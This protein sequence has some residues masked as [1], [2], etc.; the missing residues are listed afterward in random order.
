MMARIEA[1]PPYTRNLALNCLTWMIYAQKPL[2]TLD[3]Q[4]ALAMEYKITGRQ[5]L[6]LHPPMVILEACGNLL[7]EIKLQGNYGIIRPIH[8]TVKEFLTSVVE[9][10]SQQTV[11]M[12]LLDS[13]TAHRRLALVC[14]A[15]LNSMAMEEPIR[16]YSELESDIQAN[17]FE[18]YACR[19]FD[20]HVSMCDYPS[21]DIMDELG[22]LFNRKHNY[23]AAIL[24][25]RAYSFGYTRICDTRFPVSPSLVISSTQLYNV[26]SVR[27]RWMVQE[28]PK[29][30]LQLATVAGIK[31]AVSQLLKAGY[32]VNE[33]D[34]SHSTSLHYACWNKNLDLT[35]LL[36]DNGADVT[37]RRGEILISMSARGEEAFVKLLLDKHTDLNSLD[38]QR[39]ALWAAVHRGHQQIVRLLLDKGFDVDT[40]WEPIGTVLT[41][42]CKSDKDPKEMVE[43][44]LNAGA[45]PNVCSRKKSSPALFVASTKGH[46]AVVELLLEAG[47]DPNIPGEVGYSALQEA[48]RQGHETVVR[49]LLDAGADVNA[50][51]SIGT[52]IYVASLGGHAAVV[53][54]LLEAGADFR[55][56]AKNGCALRTAVRYGN[57][58]V[59]KL[60]LDA[61]AD[62]NG[63]HEEMDKRVFYSPLMFAVRN[64]SDEVVRLLLNAGADVNAQ[65]GEWR[66]LLLA[67]RLGYESVVKLLLGAGA[68]INVQNDL[69]NNPSTGTEVYSTALQAASGNGHKGIVKLLLDN[70]ADVNAQTDIQ[71]IT[72]A[73]VFANALQAASKGG[74]K[75]TVELLLEY[76]AD[77]RSLEGE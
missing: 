4:N 1:Q 31:G 73:Q 54:Q 8:Y 75:N 65:F 44:L 30:A 7:E 51:D 74:H 63:D 67:S 55:I 62:V 47:A 11:R 50:Q 18:Q 45:D 37:A 56:R 20:H 49:L 69:K 5:D 52:A 68:D 70:G 6:L 23:L 58:L 28:T 22:K 32:E 48:S 60:F 12:Q 33:V 9:G 13:N 77:P 29:Y 14:L 59:V 2:S 26:S 3:L 64:G 25:I 40:Q 16:G 21:Q 72:D 57:E 42:A 66:A 38:P 36:L 43:F 19:N 71:D 46:I 61:G 27:Q 15:Q 39:M 34:D 17:T 76:G 35:K 10:L 53:K 24:Q 41:V